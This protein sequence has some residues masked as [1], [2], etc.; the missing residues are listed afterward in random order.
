MSREDLAFVA[1]GGIDVALDR[2]DRS[3]SASIIE[4]GTWE[5]HVERVLRQY[6]VKGSVFVDIG[7]NVG[8]HTMLAASI[9]GD[10]AAVYAFEPN[11]AN[12]RLIAHTIEKNRLPNVHLLPFALSDRVGFSSFQSAIG[13]NGA[14][15]GSR[16]HDS[17]DASVTI[18]PTLRLDDLSIE[19]VDV[20]KIDVEGAEPLVLRGAE[21]TIE[22]DHPVIIFE[23]SCDM[24]ERVG[25]DAARTHL[26]MLQARGYELALI[27]QPTGEL[28]PI[29][30]VG[31]L[32]AGWGSRFRTEDILAVHR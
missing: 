24:S 12:A 20:L 14:F 15:V 18:V 13:S 17:L 30:D 1:V 9:V 23:F 3:V 4:S 28:L 8:W 29:G 6:L 19:H 2:A 22:R 31:E 32:L 11:P 7:A 21:A 5:P 26:D 10:A 25:G 16:E 27:E